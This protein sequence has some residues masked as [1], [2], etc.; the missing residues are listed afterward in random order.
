MR[1]F[2]LTSQA[3]VYTCR[4]Y[5]ILGDWNLLT[6]VNTLIDPGTDGMVSE[7]IERISTGC[8][9]VPV[10]Q[11]LLT[12]NHFDHAGG[13][14]IFR[15]RYGAKVYAWSDGRDVDELFRDGQYIKA[16][17]DMLQV[18]HTPGHSSDSVCLY[19]RRHGILFSGDTQLKARSSG[20]TFTQEYCDTLRRLSTLKIRTVYSGHDDPINENAEGM[21]LDTLCHVRNC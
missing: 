18:L 19:S 16:G 20:G 3:S 21:I 14:E 12:H 8:G 2:E 1:V 17:D 6:D 11:V 10:Q 4:S 9:K 13:C 5:L 7:Q 15:K